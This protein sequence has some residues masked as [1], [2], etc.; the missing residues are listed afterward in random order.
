MEPAPAQPTL[1]SVVMYSAKVTLSNGGLSTLAHPAM[2]T[3]LNPDDTVCLRVLTRDPR[4]DYAVPHAPYAAS[5]RA[6]HWHSPPGAA[7]AVSAASAAAAAAM[8]A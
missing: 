1:G 4:N 8:A 6:S 5:P 3:G 7:V 2:I